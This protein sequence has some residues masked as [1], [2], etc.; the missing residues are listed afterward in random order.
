MWAVFQYGD[1]IVCNG[2]GVTHD[3]RML[4]VFQYDDGIVCNGCGV[5]HD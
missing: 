4:A 1:G 3:L 2:C 5:T